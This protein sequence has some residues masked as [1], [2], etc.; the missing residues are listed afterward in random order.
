MIY[1]FLVQILFCLSNVLGKKYLNIYIEDIFL[2]LFKMGVIGWMPL[3]IYDSIFH[4]FSSND[5]F[6]HGIIP[7]FINLFREI[8]QLP[9]KIF[10]IF[11]D[12][13]CSFL[14]EICLWITV[15]YF[16][17]CHLFISQVFGE[18]T[19]TT[20]KMFINFDQNPKQYHIIQKITFYILYPIVI[21][22]VLIFNEVILLNFCGLSKNTKYQL[23]IRQKIDGNY[24][25]SKSGKIIP[26]NNA[27]RTST[28]SEE[29]EE[30]NND[31]QPLFI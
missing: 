25:I 31:E 2:L 28:L 16:T 11:L 20:L 7:F 19:D 9:K 12:L 24:D 10:L 29:D 4:I 30:E 21:F 23:N 27:N 1:F 17:P 15:Y 8:D 18:F 6:Y 3:L 5:T 14:Q 26:F 22:S 13:L